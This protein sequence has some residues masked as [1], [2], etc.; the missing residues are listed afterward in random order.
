MTKTNFKRKE[1][2]SLV[3]SHLIKAA[4]QSGGYTVP[5]SLF[6]RTMTLRERIEVHSMGLFRIPE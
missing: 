5:D 4:M 6:H 2:E 3:I 1:L